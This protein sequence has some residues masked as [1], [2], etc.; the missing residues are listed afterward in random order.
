MRRTTDAKT[1]PESLQARC[2]R[3]E[4]ER[5]GL[6][7]QLAKAND[8]LAEANAR[9]ADLTHQLSRLTHQVATGNDRLTELLAIAQR[10]RRATATTPPPQTSTALPAATPEFAKRPKAPELPPR[11]EPD[12]GPAIP[13]GRKP[14]PEHLPVD[15]HAVRPEACAHCAS[16]RF[17][18]V[19]TV[20]ERKLHVVAEHQ[21]CRVVRRIT[22]T[23]RDCG[24][25]TTARSLPAP[26]ERSKVTCEWLAWLV[27]QKFVLLTPLDRI[28]RDLA[29]RGIRLS[30]SFLVSQIERAADLLAA[31]DGEHWKQLLASNWMAHDGTGLKVLIPKVGVEGGY[32][33]VFHNT[34]QYVFQYAAEKS[35]N[36]LAE[37]LVSFQGT[38][39]AD[40]EHR[41]NAALAKPGVYEQGCNAHGRRR[42]RDAEGVQPVLAAEGGAFLAAIYAVENEAKGLGLQGDALRERR[43]NGITPI[44]RDFRDWLQAVEPTLLPDDPLA[45]TIRYYQ[46]HWD[47]LFRFVDHPELPPDNSASER[48]FQNLAKLRL[49]SLFAGSSEGAHRLATLLG[50]VATCRAVRVNAEHYLAWAFTRLGTHRDIY[51]LKAAELTPAAY[52]KGLTTPQ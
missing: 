10:K 19:D 1:T 37:K 12:R 44:Q 5:D 36:T 9:I 52:A 28:R 17:D 50:I 15:E 8:R 21:R 45:K 3:I 29:T 32:I 35:G 33:E 47:A 27:Y 14:V 51:G 13:R 48:E 22:I 42:F 30:M 25:R 18:G 34:Q 11:P 24:G 39:V 16:T 6:V 40:A 23:C 4:R 31:V 20:V 7:S 26:I 43:Q 41:H 49:N 2:D 46:T 38:F